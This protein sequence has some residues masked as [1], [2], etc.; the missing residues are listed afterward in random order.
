MAMVFVAYLVIGIA[1]PV[2][3]LHVHQGLGLGTFAV[4]LVSGSQFAAALVTRPWAGHLVDSRG[5]KQGVVV[6]LLVAALSGLL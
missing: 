5:A 2:L 3:S 1:L 4:G 6:G